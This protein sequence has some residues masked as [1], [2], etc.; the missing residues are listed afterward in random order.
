MEKDFD[1]KNIGKR[2]PYRVPGQ[3]FDNMEKN[4]LDIIEKEKVEY[5][6]ETRLPS[7]LKPRTRKRMLIYSILSAAV[8]ALLFAV[9][10]GH[11]HDD[12]TTLEDVDRAFCQLSTADQQYMLNIYQD[13]EFINY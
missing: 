7:A 13:D 5:N 2:M 12:A 10:I 4:V 8:V 11:T 1:F 9:S 3:F 6:T